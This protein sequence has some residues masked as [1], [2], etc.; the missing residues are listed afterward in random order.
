MILLRVGGNDLVFL[1]DQIKRLV[2]LIQNLGGNLAGQV[3]Y[4]LAGI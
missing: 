2:Q 3:R 1:C 4:N